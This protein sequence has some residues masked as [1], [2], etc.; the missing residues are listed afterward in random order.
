MRYLLNKLDKDIHFNPWG[1]GGDVLKVDYFFWAPGT[2]LQKSFTGLLRSLIFQLFSNA[3]EIIPR[4]VK[5]A[6]W[7]RAHIV[8]NN[9]IRWNTADL[10]QILI[11]VVEAK[12]WYTFF[13]IDGLDEFEGDD[14]EKDDFVKLIRKLSSLEHVKLCVSSRPL[15]IFLDAFGKSPKL[16][17][18]HHTEEDIYHYIDQEL[19]AEPSFEGVQKYNQALAQSLIYSILDRASGVFLWVRLVVSE[20]VKA[21]RDGDEIPQLL[22]RVEMIPKD[23]DAYFAHMMESIKSS[24]HKEASKILQVA[25]HQEHE[26]IALHPLRLI[27]L[28]CIQDND[29]SSAL[30]GSTSTTAALKLNYMHEIQFRLDPAIRR[31]N[32][33]CLCLVECQY[34]EG[35]TASDFDAPLEKGS[36]EKTIAITQIYDWQVS[37]LHR[38][39]RDF[40]LVPSNQQKLHE[41]SGGMLDARVLLCD[42]RLLQLEALV[43]S[44][45]NHHLVI[46]LASY[47][48]CAIAVPELRRTEYCVAAASR[49]KRVLD[50]VV[51]NASDDDLEA[52]PWYIGM[53]LRSYHRDCSSFLTVAIDFGLFAYVHANLTK[54]AILDK[55]GRPIIDHILICLF[56]PRFPHSIGNQ[57]PDLELLHQALEL[58]ADPNQTTGYGSPWTSF[59]IL[60]DDNINVPGQMA[61][62]VLLRAVLLLLQYGAHP[63]VPLAIM[64]SKI[65]FLK[66]P[67]LRWEGHGGR[68]AGD[69]NEMPRDL[70]FV[71]DYLA[72]L[73]PQYILAAELLEDCILLASQKA[74][75]KT[76]GGSVGK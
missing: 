32:S 76:A 41:Y 46:G 43:Q 28:I 31:V 58:G 20:L 48:I 67:K 55:K 14:K 54:K 6:M 69:L 44:T 24:Y 62:E 9:D 68:S 47:V 71:E 45:S 18:E 17:L 61:Q 7:K 64:S 59:L 1:S 56:S 29:D 39:F 65:A 37:F 11:A 38:S 73:R 34:L 22:K 30:K 50:E 66:W 63:V 40:L 27:D 53:S 52:G 49:L 51:Q 57:L 36:E 72:S 5:P 10:I 8:S 13:L 4:F 70:V 2:P 26:F 3:P 33:R 25:L 21:L 42:A 23:L 16:R 15:N 75:E 35:S 60:L 74:A 19:N 12:M